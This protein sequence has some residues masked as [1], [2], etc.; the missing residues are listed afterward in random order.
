MLGDENRI[1][2]VVTN[3]LGNARRFTA[4]DSPIELRVGVD[5]DAGTCDA[6]V[7]EGE[8]AR[9]RSENPPEVPASQTPWEEIYREKTG[10]LAEGGVMDFALKYRGTAR[11]LP[12]HNH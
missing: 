12:R 8:I 10:Q 4:D 3:L 1:R 6:L 2:Q 9:R 5:L 11:K 7:D